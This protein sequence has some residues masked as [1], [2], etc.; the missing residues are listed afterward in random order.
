MKKLSLSLLLF[1]FA[2]MAA[3][4]QYSVAYI[5]LGFGKMDV[6]SGDGS[7]KVSVDEQNKLTK[8]SIDVVA[9]MFGVNEHIKKSLSVSE[10]TA[11]ETLYFYMS[12]GLEPVLKIIPQ[13]GF[14][15]NGGKV[16][17]GIR[18]ADG[19][20]HQTIELLRGKVS[21][22]FHLWSGDSIISEIG[23]NMRGYSAPK[24]YV[25]WYEFV[26]N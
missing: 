9:G 17:F 13:A 22:K 7:L 2:H 4:A 6:S 15:A 26:T 18:K 16:K 11:G 24:M 12:G 8:I 20:H 23:I 5:N 1:L 19:F 25:G 14:N 3:A 10:L 21:K